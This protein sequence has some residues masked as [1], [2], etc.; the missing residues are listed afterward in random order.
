MAMSFKNLFP[1]VKADDDELVDPQQSLRVSSRQAL[2]SEQNCDIG[3]ILQAEC[4]ETD[5][6]KHL[7]EKYEA[8]NNRVSSKSHTTE[9]CS[10]ELFDFLHAVDHCVTKT[11][12][13]KLK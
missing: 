4:R 10:E 1:R 3:C 6:A 5:H 8:C 12:F 7:L 9:N 11:L 13:S 2:V